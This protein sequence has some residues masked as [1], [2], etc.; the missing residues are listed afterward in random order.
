M[1]DLFTFNQFW[2]IDVA[3]ENCSLWSKNFARDK[4]NQDIY[5]LTFLMYKESEKESMSN[6]QLNQVKVNIHIMP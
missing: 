2:S 6:L 3:F 4:N 5:N 1:L